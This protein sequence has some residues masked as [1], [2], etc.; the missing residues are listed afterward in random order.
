MRQQ[1]YKHLQ[2]YALL[3]T[4]AKVKHQIQPLQFL[5]H[6]LELFAQQ[7]HTVQLAHHSPFLAQLEHTIVLQQK[8]LF[9]HV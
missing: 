9:R 6:N 5:Q 7:V 1:A 3:V 8:V 4:T 2:V